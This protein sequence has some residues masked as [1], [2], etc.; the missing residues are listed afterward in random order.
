[1]PPKQKFGKE[2]IV[3]AAAKILRKEGLQGITARSL[4]EELG[5]SPRPIFTVFNSMEEVY[6]STIEYAKSLYNE[7]VAQALKQEIAFKA[8]GEAY[9]RFA[10]QEP[11][12]FQLLFMS[13]KNLD[14][15]FFNILPSIDENSHEIL[16]SITKNYALTVK[17]AHRLYMTL[18]VFTHGIASLAA[19]GVHSFSEAE[20]G[21]MMTD[22]FLGTLNQIKKENDG[23]N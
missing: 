17:S 19:T 16:D 22:V 10:H 20:M 1:M 14:S 23:E 9:I 6:S 8:V 2:E 11:K 4:A 21:Q 5:S 3:Y 7:Y 15:N 13:E 18:W 12:M